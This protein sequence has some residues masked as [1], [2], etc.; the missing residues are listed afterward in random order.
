M[1]EMGYYDEDPQNLARIGDPF[2]VNRSLMVFPIDYTE[3][4]SVFAKSPPALTFCP[5]ILSRTPD[6]TTSTFTMSLPNIKKEDTTMK[7]KKRRDGN[8]Q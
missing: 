8:S 1:C 4:P 7:E 6:T 5:R 3:C 2:N